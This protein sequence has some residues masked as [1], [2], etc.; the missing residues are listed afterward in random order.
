M[1]ESE[2]S[3]RVSKIQEQRRGRNCISAVLYVLECIVEEKYVDPHSNLTLHHL[4]EIGNIPIVGNIL[5]PEQAQAVGLWDQ[6][7]QY[8]IHLAFF[9]QDHP[10]TNQLLERPQWNRALTPPIDL[11]AFRHRYINKYPERLGKTYHL[12]FL[13][14]RDKVK[15]SIVK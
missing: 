15:P 5:V 10:E 3:R 4:E 12:H 1:I 14:K 6:Q 2:F 7:K 8:Y 11:R 9:D 13:K